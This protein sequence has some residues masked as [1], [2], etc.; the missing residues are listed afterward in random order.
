[1]QA[2]AFA[3]DFYQRLFFNNLEEVDNSNGWSQKYL[4]LTKLGLIALT[5]FIACP[6]EL[7]QAIEFYALNG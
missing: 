3:S 5:D 1:M 6:M 4:R 7:A 2:K